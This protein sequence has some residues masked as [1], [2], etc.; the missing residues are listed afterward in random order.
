MKLRKWDL[1]KLKK[2]GSEFS[3]L[4][5]E[6]VIMSK[7]GTVE[8]KWNEVKDKMTKA[9]EKVIGYEKAVVARKQWVSATML[10]K[11]E[12]RRKWK[13]V[14][15]DE[16]RRKYRQLNNELRRETEKAKEAWWEE[17]C[18][19]LE[20]LDRIGRPDLL[21]SKVKTLTKK[22]KIASKSKGIRDSNGQLVTEGDEVRKR[23]KEYIEILYSKYNKPTD[24]DFGLEKRQDLEDDF[25]G[26]VILEAEIMAAIKEMKENKSVGVDCI[27]AEFL[28]NLGPKGMK[29]IIELCKD[30]Y[31]QGTWPKDFTKVVLIPLQKKA[32]A[33][34]CEDYRT[35][36][37][38]CHAS[39]IMLKILT[40]RIECKVREFISRNQFGFKRGCGT[41]DA[42]GVMRMLT[43]R[44]LEHGQEIYIC[45][46]DFE[47][48]FD[49]VNW[50]KMMKILKSL[51]IDWRDRRLIM[52]LYMG[53]EAQIRVAGGESE[54]GIIGR[55][56]RQGCPLSPLL[57]SI[58]VEM[59]MIEAMEGV[60]EGVRI[61]GQLLQDV[62]FADDQSMVANTEKGLETIMHRLSDTAKTYDMKINV[63]KTKTMVISR[64]RGKTVNI[65]IDGKLVEQVDR[66]KYLGV[67]IT[68]DGRSLQ[69]IKERIGIAKDAFYK[70]KELLTK[71]FNRGLKKRMIKCL[72][73]PVALYG[74]ES[75]TLRKVEIE[76]LKAFEMWLWRR[77]EGVKWEDR[78]TNEE[79]LMCV[80][81]ERS[82]VQTVM[83]RKKNWIGHELRSEGLMKDVMEGG[84]DGRRVRGRPRIGML[85]EL[86]EGSYVQM[87]RRAEN[88]EKWKG[89][90]P[91][92]CQ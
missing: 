3:K 24:K 29:L 84:L 44:C 14:N 53:Q 33:V 22:E 16:G 68:D 67:V 13:A 12:E 30:M 70:R 57:F 4:V 40:K 42:I 5:D 46:V 52:E 75:W 39:K 35:I 83:R 41:R 78:K 10:E 80:G 71:K 66:F 86:K 27:P 55:G 2:N 34:E 72:V 17:E 73:W 50:V 49:R 36:S 8:E 32:N 65:A 89:W 87:K 28:K 74:C 31:E 69:S 63:K 54:S 90:V 58:Y 92:T 7:E 25:I 19:E 79:V 38:I 48:A 82:L 21:Y 51:N 64:E 47:K 15:T 11:M 37:L 9:A 1:G 85:D 59:M 76:R 6:T 62:R 20:M 23:W 91:G 26:P 56:V 18:K 60:E 81:E 88:R 45:F 77:M 61:A 43:E